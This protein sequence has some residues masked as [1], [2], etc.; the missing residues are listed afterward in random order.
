MVR[1][2]E[3][4]K[5]ESTLVEAAQI[6]GETKEA[7]SVR[8]ARAREEQKEKRAHAPSGRLGGRNE[9]LVSQEPR[10]RS[11]PWSGHSIDNTGTGRRVVLL[12]ETL[13]GS[14]KSDRMAADF[15]GGRRL[16]Y[17]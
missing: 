17:M 8:S 1:S 5:S 4:N 12:G 2:T 10:P 14:M 6:C 11:L 15:V 16:Q 7:R 3:R 13:T 9:R